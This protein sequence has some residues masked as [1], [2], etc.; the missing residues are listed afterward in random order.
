MRVILICMTTVLTWKR[1]YLYCFLY[2]R[3]LYKHQRKGELPKTP[4]EVGL[5]LEHAWCGHNLQIF[6]FCCIASCL[7]RVLNIF[8]WYIIIFNTACSMVPKAFK[9]ILSVQQDHCHPFLPRC[10]YIFFDFYFGGSVFFEA[11][12]AADMFFGKCHVKDVLAIY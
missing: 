6:S 5:Q 2:L 8:S 4:C 10:S 11:K 1:K 9:N 3:R 7:G 12:D